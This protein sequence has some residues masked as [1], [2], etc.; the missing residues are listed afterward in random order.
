MII[1]VF[2]VPAVI[3]ALT[4]SWRPATWPASSCWLSPGDVIDGL[5]AAIYGTIPDSPAVAAA[6]LPGVMFAGAALV[7]IVGAGA[8]VLRRYLSVQT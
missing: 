3:V 8:I 2:I 7:G 5:N 1:A 6:D 4:S